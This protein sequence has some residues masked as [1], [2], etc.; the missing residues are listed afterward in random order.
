MDVNIKVIQDTLGHANISTTMDIYTDITKVFK[1]NTFKKLNKPEKLLM[2]FFDANFNVNRNMI[3]VE[4][5][6]IMQM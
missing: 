6:R 3:C 4:K 2:P 5:R 1:I